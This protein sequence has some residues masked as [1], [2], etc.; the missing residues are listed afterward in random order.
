GWADEYRGRD[1]RDR[2]ALERM[3]FYAQTGFC[4]WKVL[5]EHFGEGEGFDKCGRCDNCVSPPLRRLTPPK[6]RATTVRAPR[7]RT[8][9]RPGDYAD[10][11]RYGR[12]RVVSANESSVTLEFPDG[13][14]RDFVPQFVRRAEK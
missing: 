4:R 14:R 10:V 13:T 5:L 9:Y 2:A 7:P 8:P 1:E 3:V 6:R 11:Q 12:G